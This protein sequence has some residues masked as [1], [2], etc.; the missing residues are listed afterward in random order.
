MM[1][2]SFAQ[3][4]GTV[5]GTVIDK[6]MNSEPLPF[7]SV[8]VKGTAI[9]TNTD[10]NGKYTLSVP[11]GQQT[12]VFGFLGYE[13]VEA[14]ITVIAGETQTV[15][16]TL[17][18]TSVQ[19]ED[20]VI[21]TVRTRN[22]ESALVLEMREAKQI[23]SG[24]SAEQMAKSTDNNA[25]E[26]VQRVPGVT[27]VDGK[28]VM[29]RGLSERYNNVLLNGSIAPSTEIDK[30]TFAFDLISTSSLDK[31]VIYKTGSAD[32]P[33]DFAG[34]IIAVTTAENTTEFT[35]VGVGAGYRTG[36]TFG[37][38][39]QSE[40]GDT[41]FLGFD[42]SYRPLPNGFSANAAT[43][44]V[45][46]AQAHTL[47][48]NFNPTN[49]TAFLDTRL[50]FSLGRRIKIGGANNSLFTI[51]SLSYSNAYQSVDRQFTRYTT[52]NPGE[53]VA[54]KWFDYRDN[55][56]QNEIN[57]TLFS[58]WILRLG[59]NTKIKFKNLFNQK[60]RNETTVRNGNDFQD[61]G[62]DLLRNYYLQYQS[63]TLYTGQLEGEHK[64]ANN[65]V[66]WVIGYNNL[67]DNM[68]D[69]R[70]FR[71]FIP[72]AN[73]NSSYLMIDPPGSN[74]F[75]TGRYFGELNEYSINNGVNFT[76]T[77]KRV[78]GDEELSDI[79]LKAGYYASY[80]KRDF[81]AQYFTYIIPGYVSLDRANE[82]RAL[83]LDQVF[84]N[85]NVNS[86]N[87]WS[88]REGTS[89]TDSYTADNLYLAGYLQGQ[90]S[91]N[92]FDITAGV[93]LEQNN[94]TL[95]S[96]TYASVVNVDNPVTSVL[97]SL[98]VGYNLNEKSLLRFAYSRTVNRP[99]F[100]ELAP[101]VF[102]DYTTQA[103]LSGNPDLKTA[104][105]DNIDL[106]Y[107]FYPTKSE[108]ASFGAFYKRFKNPIELTT[109][110]AGN[111]Q[112]QF[113]NAASANNYG[114]EV[115]VKK[116]FNGWTNST[117]IDRLSLNLNASYIVSE[118]DLGSG[119]VAQQQK[120]ALQ[121][122]SPYIVNAALG[123]K[124]DKDF[125][126]N[127]V[128]N[129][130]GDRIFSAGDNNFPSIYELARNNL[131]MTVSKKV[132]ATTFKLGIQNLLNDKYRFYEDSDRSE[133]INTGKDNATSVLR[134]GTLFTLNVTYNF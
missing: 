47:P 63:S 61:R 133:D 128:Y 88:L 10:E 33:G 103:T 2:V 120:R 39:L 40:G 106:K 122:Q 90:F 110:I 81:A 25:A 76:H 118:V 114:V 116:S 3:D 8:S 9:S 96:E 12:I 7:A 60:G 125:S 35:K 86:V 101:F 95:D 44:I 21:E 28:F 72:A 52:L 119:V 102:Y 46:D 124:D 65:T 56:Y 134:R 85:T 77:I 36:T 1:A 130:F 53:T 93:R 6:D 74:P 129:R 115:E 17:T 123:Y 29:I 127:F 92:K 55:T 43:R 68:P 82:L 64:L 23:T 132:N 67:S 91:L 57:T 18:S 66:D 19:M 69:F 49:R 98:N 59:D 121:G 20:V 131:D 105:I 73:P 26:A 104:N 108:T 27:I 41:D 100:R 94:Q 80:R 79:I 126:V 37:D 71:T 87:G 89:P 111:P 50:G 78:R 42:K 14:V 51:N 99:E 38:Y 113:N 54:P 24:I 13:T 107:E 30:R 4:K 31:M 34:G 5:T 22:T 16:K 58:N 32:K 109:Q 112:F 84:N 62:N 83:P 75:D 45:S 117:F 11:A 70:R 15:N 48:N 97:P